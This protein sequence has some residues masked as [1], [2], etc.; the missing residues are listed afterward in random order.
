MGVQQALII[1]IMWFVIDLH[2]MVPPIGQRVKLVQEGI[3]EYDGKVG[4]DRAQ[5]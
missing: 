4:V 3:A 5:E 1:G 2:C